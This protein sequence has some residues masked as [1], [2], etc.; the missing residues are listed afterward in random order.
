MK[1]QESLSCSERQDLETAPIGWHTAI[2]GR[3]RSEKDLCPYG[4]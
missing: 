4:S 3:S 2:A 1:N